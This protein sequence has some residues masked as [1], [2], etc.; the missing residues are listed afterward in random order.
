VSARVVRADIDSMLWL[1]RMIVMLD[2]EAIELD[3][4]VSAF[5]ASTAELRFNVSDDHR[6]FDD[7]SA[8]E[9]LEYA[10]LL[11]MKR[12]ESIQGDKVSPPRIHARLADL[13]LMREMVEAKCAGIGAE[14]SDPCQEC[15]GA[16]FVTYPEGVM[17]CSAIHPGPLQPRRQCAK[18]PR[19]FL[20]NG[21]ADAC[22]LR[23]LTGDSW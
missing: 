8:F 18:H 12:A 17:R 13:K 11:L 9:L 19:C 16:G 15:G 20:D 23:E 14:V 22:R 2:A 10:S 1:A 21:H 3:N 7:M 4:C 6:Q 5:G